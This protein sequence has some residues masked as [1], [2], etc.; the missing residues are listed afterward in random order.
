MPNLDLGRR[1]EERALRWL[2]SQGYRIV[3]RNWRW[4]GGEVDLIARDGDYLV[5][6]EVK[7]RTDEGFGR[8]EEALTPAKRERLI[9]AAR[10]YVATYR[11]ELELRFDVVAIEGEEIR[12]YRDAFQVEE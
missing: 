8:P 9:R 7:T 11:P 1:G 3:A 5:F 6:I 2:K 12:L 10:H 4:R